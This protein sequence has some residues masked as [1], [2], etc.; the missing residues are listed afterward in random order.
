MKN[1]AALE[2]GQTIHTQLVY[3]VAAQM[4]ASD[5]VSTKYGSAHDPENHPYKGYTRAD[6]SDEPIGGISYLIIETASEYIPSLPVLRYLVN[7]NDSSIEQGAAYR[8]SIC[9]IYTSEDENFVKYINPQEIILSNQNS[10]DGNFDIRV[11]IF[12]ENNALSDSDET[13]FNYTIRGNVAAPTPLPNTSLDN[14]TEVSVGEKISLIGDAGSLIFYTTNGT[15]PNV[16]LD[17]ANVSWVI[18]TPEGEEPTTFLFDSR[19]P[20]IPMDDDQLFTINAIAVSAKDELESTSAQPFV[21]KVKKLEQSSIPISIPAT[22]VDN[23][24]NIQFGSTIELTTTTLNADIYYTINGTIPSVE[25]RDNWDIAYAAATDKGTDA[26]TEKRWYMDQGSKIYE[27]ATMIYNPQRPI[28]MT[29][30]QAS[31][32][33][34]VTAITKEKTIPPKLSQS[35]AVS[36][37]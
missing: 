31:M 29:A 26:D 2:P 36:F 15:L 37:T 34:T 33:F 7:D 25:D 10:V 8:Y 23:V 6:S 3:R 30:T 16:T 20:I 1:N 32:L 21:Y 12:A 9:Q 5:G 17:E 4:E 27:P 11:K 35:D 24:T 13:K 14:I 18:N 22:S 28:K 19:T